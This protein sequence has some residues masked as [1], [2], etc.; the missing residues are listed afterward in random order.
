[1]T[2]DK[3]LSALR[4]E[5]RELQQAMADVR[6]VRTLIARSFEPMTHAE[7]IAWEVEVNAL[8]KGTGIQL[9]TSR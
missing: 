1:M 4:A 5:S 6:R 9:E 3:T 8:L 2:T 7:R